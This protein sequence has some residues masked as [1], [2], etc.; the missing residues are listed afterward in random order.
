M[1]S[2]TQKDDWLISP[3]LSAV[4]QTIRFNALSAV[5]KKT[6]N[7]ELL[8]SD[9]TTDVKDFQL[10]KTITVEPTGRWDEYSFNVPASAHMRYLPY[11][12]VRSRVAV[13]RCLWRAVLQA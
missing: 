5:A 12:R 3:R 8:Y 11:M 9:K 7:V 1:P 10:V 4:A 6:A 13:Y 2:S